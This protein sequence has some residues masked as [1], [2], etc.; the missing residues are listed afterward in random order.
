MADAVDGGELRRLAEHAWRLHADASRQTT[1]VVHP[2]MPILY[3]GDLDRYF[4]SELRIITVGL[5]PSREEF[6]PLIHGCGSPRA[7]RSTSTSR[8]SRTICAV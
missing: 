1:T 7:Q 8:N 3:Y 6:L 4:A 2:S 5:N